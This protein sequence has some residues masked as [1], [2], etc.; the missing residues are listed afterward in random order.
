MSRRNRSLDAAAA[1]LLAIAVLGALAARPA[2]APSPTPPAAPGP[3]MGAVPVHIA[4]I[5]PTGP[6]QVLLL[7]ADD[8]ERQAPPRHQE[9]PGATIPLRTGPPPPAVRPRR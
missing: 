1:L 6:D 8:G 7:L 9:T 5:R 2:P 3:A 4:G